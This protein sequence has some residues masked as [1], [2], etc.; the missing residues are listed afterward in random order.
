MLETWVL[1]LA[2]EDPTCCGTTKP[3]QSQLLN[4]RSATQDRQLLSPHA[5][6]AEARVPEGPCSAT[7]EAMAMRSLC[8]AA[9]E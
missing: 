3:M 7:R 4:L 6:T 8:P 5:A 2:W 1:S 9:R